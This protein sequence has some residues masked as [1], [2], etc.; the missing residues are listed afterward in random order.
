MDTNLK[1]HEGETGTQPR[2]RFRLSLKAIAKIFAV[3]GIDLSPEDQA[4]LRRREGQ[5]TSTEQH[6]QKHGTRI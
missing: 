2:G 5:S 4:E 6:S 3:E 1:H